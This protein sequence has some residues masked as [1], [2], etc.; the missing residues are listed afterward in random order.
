MK[1]YFVAGLLLIFFQSSIAQELKYA[2]EDLKISQAIEGTLTTPV[3]KEAESLVIFIQGSG[4]T[5]RNGNQPMMK[6]DG[7]RK[8][9]YQLAENGI[10]S[11]RFDKRIFKMDELKIKEKDLRFDDFVLDVKDILK[12]FEEKDKF[13]NLILA[14]HS[15]G[16][17][18]GILASQEMADGFIS[19]AGAGQPIDNIIV[20]QVHKMAPPLAENARTA[21]NEIRETGQTTTYSPMLESMFKPSI[22]PFMHSWMKYNPAEEIAKLDIPVLI[23]NG[24]EDIQVET[25]EAEFLKNASDD[26]QLVII[27]NMNHIFRKIESKDRLV[28]TKSYNEPNQPLHPDLIPV[29]TEFVKELE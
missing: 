27:E 25:K 8:I 24:S 29:I 16:S 23:I 28:N 2:E 18:V 3:S 12:Y 14:G 21:F 4:P 1:N 15:Q 6:N 9:A 10:A 22:Q 11:F 7:M 19:L 13:D 5:D 17:L 20:E 26:A